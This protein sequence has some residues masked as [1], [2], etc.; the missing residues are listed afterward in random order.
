MAFD[1]AQYWETRYSQGRTSGSGS[2]GRLAQYK[3]DFLNKLIEEKQVKSVLDMG[4]GD[5]NQ[6]SM[7]RDV[8]YVGADVSISV[9]EKNR[10]RFAGRPNT[11]FVHVDDLAVTDRFDLTMS[12]DVI[13]HL[14]E[15]DIFKRY[16]R[17]LFRHS[18][19]Y[20]AI[21]ASNKVSPVRASHIKHR[22]FTSF[23][24]KKLKNWTLVQNEPNPFPWDPENKNETSFANFHVFASLREAGTRKT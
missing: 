13:Y 12:N 11:K 6:L 3:A 23:V 20:V 1:S 2:Y 17:S 22:K 4:C 21:Y 19:R 7:L 8:P 9:L 10:E 16:M 15:D 5:G 24:A 14:V 18:R